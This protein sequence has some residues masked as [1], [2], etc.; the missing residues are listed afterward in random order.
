MSGHADI[1]PL[2]HSRDR[3]DGH[4][5]PFRGCPA[6]PVSWTW[7]PKTKR[8]RQGRTKWMTA[9]LLVLVQ[10]ECTFTPIPL[11][12]ATSANTFSRPRTHERLTAL[13]AKTGL[14]FMSAQRLWLGDRWRAHASSY[15]MDS[16][17][18]VLISWWHLNPV[19]Q[20]RSVF[21]KGA[22]LPVCCR[23]FSSYYP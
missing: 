5:P 20:P 4:P 14:G 13:Q 7:K 23:V 11:V 15:T 21:F 16:E 9:R 19:P 10:R 22:N 3:P 1:C 2:G 17:G 8:A 6:C 12:F 18:V